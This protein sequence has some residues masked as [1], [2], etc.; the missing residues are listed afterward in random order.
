MGQIDLAFTSK[1]IDPKDHILSVLIEADSFVYGV[2]D[3]HHTL[4]SAG[5]HNINLQSNVPIDVLVS[6]KLIVTGYYK[7]VI[8]YSTKE[9]A[10]LSPLDFGSGDFG[11]YFNDI[12]V[13]DEILSDKFTDSD[14]HVVFKVNKNL[15]QQI[16]DIL[17][18]TSEV[19]VSTALGQYVYPSQSSRNIVMVSS[20]RLHY[21]SYNG[22]NLNMYNAYQYRTKEDFLYYLQL[23]TDF[24]GIDREKDILEIGGWLDQTSD[25]Y[26]LISPYYRNIQWV[27][28][29]SMSLF[30]K[31]KNHLKHHYFAIYA[32]AL[33][34]S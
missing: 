17:S 9:F 7:T 26:K 24:A 16:N 21:M 5:V 28:M 14:V 1:N 11:I 23:A 33:C 30:S 18:P 32:T 2:F 20:D 27:N 8:S 34:V 10:H 15:R 4:V 3:R 29:P 19:H 22:G 25:I 13:G 12:S 31:N 6:D